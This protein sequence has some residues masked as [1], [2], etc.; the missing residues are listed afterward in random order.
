MPATLLDKIWDPHVVA[1]L[2]NGWSLLYCA[3]VLVHDLSG[4][5]ALQ[6]VGEAGYT[7]ARPDRVFATPD[8]AVSSAPGRTAETFPTGAKLIAGLR[9]RTAETG[10]RM[11]D[12]GQDGNGIVHVMAPELGIVLPGTTLV[13]GDSHT[14][15]N[16][17]VG[18]LAFGI[19]ASELKHVLATQL[20]VD[21]VA[22][23]KQVERIHYAINRWVQ[24]AVLTPNAAQRR[25]LHGVRVLP[26]GRALERSPRVH[27]SCSRVS[28][29]SDQRLQLGSEQ[30]T[31]GRTHPLGD[32]AER[33][34]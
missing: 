2:G 31:T 9:K 23:A 1:D 15:T 3:R 12:L 16:G 28:G 20:G 34:R 6:E 17:G 30:I 10:V 25:M 18:A 27:A 11:F 21:V 19:G 4:G 24:G 5:R 29:A 26:R 7:V 22:A 13:C 32:R 33:R 14:C 8:H